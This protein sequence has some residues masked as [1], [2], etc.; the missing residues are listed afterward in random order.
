MFEDI[1]WLVIYIFAVFSHHTKICYNLPLCIFAG[2]LN[3]L[4]NTPGPQTDENGVKKRSCD[5]LM[6]VTDKTRADVKGGT[7]VE[8]EGKLRLLEI[9]QVCSSW[10]GGPVIFIWKCCELKTLI[11]INSFSTLRYGWFLNTFLDPFNQR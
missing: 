8:Y 6:E 9:A 4:N 1:K 2:I 3:F 10:Q 5:F 11:F 7:L